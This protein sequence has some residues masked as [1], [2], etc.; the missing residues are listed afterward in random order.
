MIKLGE[1][2]L[3]RAGTAMS[4]FRQLCLFVPLSVVEQGR[5]LGN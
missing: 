1:D 5:D 2:W 4:D 3:T